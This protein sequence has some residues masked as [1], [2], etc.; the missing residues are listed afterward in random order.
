MLDDTQVP[1]LTSLNLSSSTRNLASGQTSITVTAHFADDLSGVFDGTF[2]DGS[3]GSPPQIRFVSPSGQNV[4]GLFDILH[5]VSG[6]RLDGVYRATVTL[7]PTAE[8]GQ[9]HVGSLLL[10]DEAGNA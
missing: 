3:G 4:T 1:T 2:A 9:W 7:A 5:P 6:D 8:A 10:N